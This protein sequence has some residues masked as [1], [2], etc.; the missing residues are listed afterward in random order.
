MRIL[1]VFGTDLRLNTYFMLLFLVYWHL[2]ILWQALVIFCTVFLHELG[3]IVVAIGYG[4]RVREVELLPFGGVARLEGNIELDPAVETCVSLAGP[5][6]NGFLAMLGYLV[7][8]CGMGNQKWLPFFIQCNLLLGLFNMVPAIP[9]DG[10]RLFRAA[11]SRRTGL[12]RAT[13]RAVLLSRWIGGS[14]ALVGLW[15]VFRDGGEYLNFLVI[16]VFLLYSAAKEKGSAMYVF[17]KFLARKKEE[18]VREGIL[19]T[20]QL[21]AM[22]TSFLKDVVKFFVPGKYHLVVVM[23]RDQKVRGTVTEGEIIDAMLRGGQDTRL[24][25]LVQKK[26]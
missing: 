10:G 25:A 6:T 24:G 1:T 8:L 4:I 5:I 22:E 21:A 11:L 20:R 17:M 16:A 19:L 14:M 12:K 7:N 26:N 23:G 18:L 2:G 9:L 13:D 3:H 15:S